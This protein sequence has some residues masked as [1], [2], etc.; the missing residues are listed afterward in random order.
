MKDSTQLILEKLKH[1]KAHYLQLKDTIEKLIK[2]LDQ[3]AKEIK[4]HKNVEEQARIYE[5]WRVARK[6]V[7]KKLREALAQI[8]IH[9]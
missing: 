3:V 4:N 7:F 8:E 9:Y 5:G 6:E 1:E 2:H